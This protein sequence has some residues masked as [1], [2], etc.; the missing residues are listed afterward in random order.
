VRDVGK[1]LDAES[2]GVAS[3]LPRGLSNPSPTSTP[4][5]IDVT[6]DGKFILAVAADQPQL[7]LSARRKSKW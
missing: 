5:N 3:P 2:F 7:R 1:Q 4:R 6:R